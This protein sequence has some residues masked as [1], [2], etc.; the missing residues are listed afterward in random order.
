VPPTYGQLLSPSPDPY[1][2]SLTPPTTRNPQQPT[3]TCE[4]R[5]QSIAI[6]ARYPR[7]AVVLGVDPRWHLPLLLCR[8]LSTLPSVWWVLQACWSLWQIY[9]KAELTGSA[10]VQGDRGG[11]NDVTFWRI[12]VAQVGLSF[13]WVRVCHLDL[14]P[15]ASYALSLP[16]Q[17][18]GINADCLIRPAQQHI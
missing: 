8:A 12:A 9:S 11:E 16:D 7:V 18:V 6:S 4:Q 5:K 2:A 14:P 1:V 15:K 10:E 17:A 3:T 13:I